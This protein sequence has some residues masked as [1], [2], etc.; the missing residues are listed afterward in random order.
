M[1]KPSK[2]NFTRRRKKVGDLY[3][4]ETAKGLAYFQYNLENHEWSSLIRVLQGFYKSRPSQGCLAELVKKSHRFQQFLALNKAIRE[5]EV[6]FIETFPVPEFA[7]KLP[8]FKGSNHHKTPP[9]D[10][11]WYLWNGEKTWCAGKLSF[12]EQKKYPLR[13]LCDATALKHF[14]ETGMSLRDK[15]C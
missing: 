11:I 7:Q 12:E 4:I 1:N 5:K 13:G 15:L 3:E 9:E 2:K 10:K 6:S 14:I 8:I